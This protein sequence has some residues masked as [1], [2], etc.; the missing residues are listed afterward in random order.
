MRFKSMK[1]WFVSIICICLFAG[2]V[3]YA[4]KSLDN[5]TSEEKFQHLDEYPV[6]FEKEAELMHE[7]ILI[8]DYLPVEEALK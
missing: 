6:L 7:L 5:Y 2:N 3:V 8:H 4:D 1:R